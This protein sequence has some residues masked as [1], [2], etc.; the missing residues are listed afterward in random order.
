MKRFYTT[1]AKFLSAMVLLMGLFSSSNLSAQTMFSKNIY[2][3]NPARIN[4]AY[5]GSQGKFFM[6]FQSSIGGENEFDLPTYSSINA[7]YALKDNL[8]I[9]VNFLSEK[10]GPISITSADGGASY[11]S[12]FG[13]DHS[14]SFGMT[15]G[16]FRST[17]NGD[18]FSGNPLVNPD[19][20]LL[21][22][23]F[24]DESYMKLGAG[25]VYRY[26]NLELGIGAPYL[27]RG[28]ESF[29]EAGN[30]LL[31]YHI[32][33]ETAKLTFSPSV[34]YEIRPDEPNIYDVNL[35]SEWN[36][37]VRLLIG[38]RSNESLNTGLYINTGFVQIGYNYNSAMGDEVQAIN[39][40][41]HEL[42]VAMRLAK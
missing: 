39:D 17:L 28:G 33:V 42:L 2:I 21:A 27:F 13:E 25:I 40:G 41:N 31:T 1:S 24:L 37:I 23:G 4:P 6:G 12:A 30:A 11:T 5:M 7:H 16:F 36:N 19:D 26:K 35:L 32:P 9:G 20:P 8:G 15:L 18:V 10:Q 38:Y 29:N 3:V 22:E 34:F 14:L